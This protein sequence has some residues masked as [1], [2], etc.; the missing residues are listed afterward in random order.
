MFIVF[1]NHKTKLLFA[2][3]HSRVQSVDSLGDGSQVTQI[4]IYQPDTFP[5]Y[6]L[7]EVTGAFHETVAKLN[8]SA[9]VLPMKVAS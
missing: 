6:A 4:T 5:K 9:R 7:V 8:Q 3:D 2:V 1:E